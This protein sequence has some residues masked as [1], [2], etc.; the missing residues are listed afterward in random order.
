MRLGASLRGFRT[1][2]SAAFSCWL[3]RRVC[4]G[5]KSWVCNGGMWTFSGGFLSVRRGLVK[6]SSDG[7]VLSDPKSGRGRVVDLG[8][9][10]IRGL[11][12]HLETFPGN[13][14]FVF[15]HSGGEPLR[16][17][18]VSKALPAGC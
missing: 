3:S 6:V 15:C 2:C 13:G 8:S 18:T 7:A 11:R 16:P 12:S 9:D 5:R 1:R 4:A 14:N 10:A 17:V